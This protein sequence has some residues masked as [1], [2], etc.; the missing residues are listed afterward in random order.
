MLVGILFA[1]AWAFIVTYALLWLINKI[2]P[3]RVSKAD[4]EKG[5]DIALHGENAYINE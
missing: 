2:T 4:E 5:L 3:V 1:I